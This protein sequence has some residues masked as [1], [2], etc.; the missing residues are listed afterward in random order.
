MKT[1]FR[2][3]DH[4]RRTSPLAPPPDGYFDRLPRRVM[5]RVQPAPVS[6]GFLSG[7][8]A[9]LSRPVRTALASAVV[10]GGFATSF[11]LGQ[12]V[13]PSAPAAQSVSA[14]VALASVPRAEMVQ[15]LL[16]SDQRVSLPDLAD[17]PSAADQ[18]V[19][20]SFLHAS[21]DEVQQALDDQPTDDI[22]L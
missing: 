21:A 7:W 8:V 18:T 6:E 4:P 1:P 11:F 19:T 9:Q 2:L 17:L 10:L 16:A 5:E 13:A 12:A 22:Y 14:E 20:D 15:Y 3:D